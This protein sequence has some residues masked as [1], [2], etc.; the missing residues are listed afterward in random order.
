MYDNQ[1]N[2]MAAIYDPDRFFWRKS[3]ESKLKQV[4]LNEWQQSLRPNKN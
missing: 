1:M 3:M 2:P 4:P